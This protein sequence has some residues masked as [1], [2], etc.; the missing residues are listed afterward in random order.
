MRRAAAVRALEAAARAGDAAGV[1]AALDSGA[2]VA[3]RTAAGETALQLAAEAN[4]TE[5]IAALLQRN[6]VVDAP[7]KAGLTPLHAAAAAGAV[8]SIAALLAAGADVAAQTKGAQVPLQ[9]AAVAGHPAACKALLEAG[10]PVDRVI[11]NSAKE[12]ECRYMILQAVGAPNA[13]AVFVR[14]RARVLTR[15][16]S[17][18]AAQR[19]STTSCARRRWLTLRQR[20]KRSRSQKKRRNGE[21]ALQSGRLYPRRH[22]WRVT[23]SILMHPRRTRHANANGHTRKLKRKRSA[24][25]CRARTWHRAPRNA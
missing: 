19:K 1:T 4:G 18:G 12:A 10:S 13:A 7:D 25:K 24:D 23:I 20:N 2:S 14:A 8:D 11:Y 22:Y 16:L 5:A 17:L 15:F 3:W 21:A 9:L 6:A